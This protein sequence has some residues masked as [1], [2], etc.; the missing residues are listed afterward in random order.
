MV[1]ADFQVEDIDN[2]PRFF[3]KIF[4]IANTKFMLILGIFFLKISNAD[5]LFGENTLTWKFYTTSK[6][7]SITK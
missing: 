2:R 1:I 7:L 6:A 4:L 3:Q 5:I